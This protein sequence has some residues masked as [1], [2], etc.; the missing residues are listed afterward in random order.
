MNI[1]ETT[2]P[3]SIDFLKKYFE[4]PTTSYII[5]YANSTLKG[6]KLLIYLNNLDFPVDLKID[7]DSE[8]FQELLVEYFKCPY[9]LNIKILEEAAFESMMLHRGLMQDPHP[10]TQRFVDEN[11]ELV[12]VWAS[13]LDSCTLYNFYCL[14]DP[15]FDDFIKSHPEDTTSNFA[16]NFVNLLKYSEFY[17][18]YQNVNTDGLKYY[19]VYF[20]EYVFKGK[21]LFS[22]W[23]NEENPLFLL[24]SAI[25]DDYINEELDK[26]SS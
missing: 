7:I 21:N 4:D 19:S 18:F 22:Y 16:V 26:L 24:T 14:K 23:A 8:E 25:A 11:S 15:E 5:D 6:Q 20:N 17:S 12:S 1:I 10:S 9:V 13:L 2:A 3:I